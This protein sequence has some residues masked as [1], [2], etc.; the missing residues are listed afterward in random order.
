MNIRRSLPYIVMVGVM[1]IVIAISLNF[2]LL[3]NEQTAAVILPDTSPGIQDGDHSSGENAQGEGIIKITPETVAYAIG[4]LSR[5]EAYSRTL[6]VTNFWS[7]GQGKSAID[8]YVSGDDT[9]AVINGEKHILISGDTLS[10]W[11]SGQT[12]V[13]T[14][15]ASE[16]D[17]DEFQTIPTYE[18]I[19]SL[20]PEDI[21]DAGYIPYNGENCIYVVY[22]TG[23]MHYS[24]TVHIS[25]ATG[26]LT[27][28]SIYDGESL[29][30]TVTSD[31]VS[32]L[33][34]NYE[35]FAVPSL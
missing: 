20:D 26:L 18:D 27:A 22:V 35:N 28:C 10:I 17:D 14:G 7:G 13:F 33:P 15:K 21:T 34:P 32:L 23:E 31:N 6:T 16:N 11:Y 30:Y 8:V 3:Q 1:V 5:P 24:T 9:K 19:L 29:I 2:G 12:N 25:V 4:A